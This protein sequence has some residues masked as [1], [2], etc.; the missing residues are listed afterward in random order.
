MALNDEK[1]LWDIVRGLEAAWDRGD[2]A[3]WAC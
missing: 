2:S 3:A 1:N